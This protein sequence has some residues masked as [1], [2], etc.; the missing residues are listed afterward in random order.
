MKHN[1]HSQKLFIENKID[2]ND[3]K[4]TESLFALGNGYLGLRGTYDERCED[5]DS[6]P[7]MYINGIFESEPLKHLWLCKGFAENEQYTINLPDWRIFEVYI[8]GEKAVTKNL[9][10]HKRTLDMENGNI[11]R[12]FE[13]TTGTGKTVLVESLRIVD[14]T[15]VHSAHIRY[16]VKPVN[17]DGTVEL[18][19]VVVKNTPING[20]IT[21]KTIYENVTDNGLQ[22]MV[23]TNRTKKQVACSVVHMVSV[24]G[25]GT[26]GETGSWESTTW[27]QENK[28]SL[29]IRAEMKENEK[30]TVDKFASFYSTED[31][32]YTSGGLIKAAEETACQN[33]Q[34]GFETLQKRQVDFWVDYWK[35]G[36]VII[37]GN[38]ADQ[39]AV[40]FSLFHLRQQLPVNNNASIG[41]TGLTGANYSGKVFWDTEMYL[42]PY[43][44]YTYPESCK[45][46]L[47]YRYK[48]LDK[49]RERAAQL[50]AM[51]ALYSW[52]SIDGEETSVVFEASTA[53]YHINSDVAYAI[54]RYV[55]VTEDVDFLYNYGAE[56]L[57]ETA[58]FMAHRGC[59]VETKDNHFCINAVCGPD[60]YACG[61]NN[62][63]YTNFMVQFHLRYALKVYEEMQKRNPEKL[64]T[65]VEKVLLDEQ[66]LTLWREAADRMYYH[67][68]E[69]LGVYEQDDSF[70]Y[71]D[72]VDMNTIPRNYDIR[73]MFHP[74]DLWRM[75][76]LKQAD[77]VLLNFVLGDKFTPAEK[78]ANY[79]Y[80]EPKTNHGSSLSAAVHS[81]MA[82]EIGYI[83]DAYKYFES[84]AFMDID[85]FKKNTSGGLHIACLGGVWMCVVHGFLG[86]RMYEDGLHFN[87]KLPKQW[88]GCTCR[89]WYK[90]NQIEIN[91]ASEET[92]FKLLK[93]NSVMINVYGNRVSLDRENQMVTVKN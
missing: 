13:F 27:N 1:I 38:E 36:D 88:T 43:Y 83:E 54:W 35:N 86:M 25:T 64:T 45:G 20:K 22:I 90:E 73:M 48:I 85:D 55:E 7:G 14:M 65:L 82:N 56:I 76:V 46:L 32:D 40:R 23:E 19:S 49:A 16:C 62:N 39:Q 44:L 6:D 3:L 75:Q 69:Q 81:I 31:K 53:E 11:H 26:D 91:A 60:E 8:D 29:Q 12:M 67:V 59:F 84:S 89:V 9:K 30:L 68:N 70:V 21:T 66:E 47:M 87:V 18:C 92:C 50:G 74:L 57:F 79:D 41:A 71:N 5:F 37:K 63:C 80:Y 15:D 28:Y 17:F 34:L 61:V 77:V 2:F 58:K 42:M 33:I 78:K 4:H 72:A 10:N 24:T 52:C 51:G 93:G